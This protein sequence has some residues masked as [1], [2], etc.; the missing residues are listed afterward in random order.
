MLEMIVP[1][2]T[3][4]S[5]K[6][7][8]ADP[9]TEPAEQSAALSPNWG[10]NIKLIVGLTLAAILVT[11]LFYFRSLIGPV[12]LAFILSYLLHPLANGLSKVSGLSWRGAVN[13]IY[14]VLFVLLAVSITLAGLAVVQQIENLFQVIQ[15]FVNNLPTLVAD[16]S[17]QV[18]TIGPFELDMSTLNL[19]MAT[20]RILSSVQ[21][22][23]AQL[24]ILVSAFATSAATTLGWGL[25]VLVISYFLM[26]EA[27]QVPKEL[28]YAD[29]PGFDDDI[30]R[31]GN[32]L[33]RVWNAFLRGQLTVISM[34]I[35]SYTV[36]MTVLGVR[37]ALAIALLAGLSRFVPYLGPLTAWTV[38]GMVTFFQSSNY[39]G[40]S[41]LQYT[42][43]VIIAAIVLDQIFDNLVSP[44]IF[45]TTLDIHPAAV[46]IAAIVAANLIG[47]LGLILAAPTVA[48]LKLLGRYV[49]RKMLDLDPWPLMESPPRR[50]STPYHKRAIRRLQAWYYLVKQRQ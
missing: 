33:R 42:L 8:P 14:L 5:N 48:T 6:L 11:L 45:G 32:E 49:L 47:L 1:S 31:L 30:R 26:A 16:L 21:P 10:S 41:P 28:L 44:R 50:H 43:M 20:E 9:T 23:I 12:L 37:Y 46:L 18:F 19:A 27:N 25:F 34:V 15:R 22:V 38:L 7:T 36:L 35:I 3:P 39:F 40:L 29:L 13:I 24:G 2:T 17:T 4:P